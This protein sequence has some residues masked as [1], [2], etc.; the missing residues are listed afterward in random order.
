MEVRAKTPDTSDAI[1]N[2]LIQR[3]IVLLEVPRSRSAS[4]LG[5]TCVIFT[6]SELIDQVIVVFDVNVGMFQAGPHSSLMK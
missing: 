6:K 3:A 2:R 1:F 5:N 4:C